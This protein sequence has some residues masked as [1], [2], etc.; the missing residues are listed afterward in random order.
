MRVDMSGANPLTFALLVSGSLALPRSGANPCFELASGVLAFTFDGLRCAGGGTVRHG[1]RPT[2]LSG[3][4][5]ASNS[6][7]GL[8]PHFI[9]RAGFVAGQ[10]RIYQAYYR[11]LPTMVCGRGLNTTQAFSVTF[12]P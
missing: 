9:A 12:V 10:S 3:E 1:I 7:W 6:P 11:E 4:V 8:D 5:G 2:D